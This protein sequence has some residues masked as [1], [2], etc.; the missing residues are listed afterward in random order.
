MVNPETPYIQNLNSDLEHRDHVG[1]GRARK[2]PQWLESTQRK[3]DRIYYTHDT[4]MR[5]SFNGRYI[6][7]ITFM[8]PK[9]VFI[10]FVRFC[11]LPIALLR[12][13]AII[14]LCKTHMRSQKKSRTSSTHIRKRR[15]SSRWRI[16][17]SLL[18]NRES[19]SYK[20]KS[21]RSLA[22]S[23]VNRQVDSFSSLGC[24]NWLRP[25]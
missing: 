5:R 12:H 7:R 17:R 22:C 8:S 24:R 11:L 18:S 19:I 10:F 13:R 21:K 3:N 14:R 23:P 1:D 25:D 20:P 4:D 6:L 15:P 9:N 16:R 2:N